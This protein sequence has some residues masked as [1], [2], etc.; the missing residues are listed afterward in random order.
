MNTDKVMCR[1]WYVGQRQ[2]SAITSRARKCHAE[3]M[4]G[5]SVCSGALFFAPPFFSYK[6]L[7]PPCLTSFCVSSPDACTEF[8]VSQS[9][10]AEGVISSWF[11]IRVV[12]TET[13]ASVM[14][15][16]SPDGFGTSLLTTHDDNLTCRNTNTYSDEYLYF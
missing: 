8:V 6:S 4:V 5:R 2:K 15:A 14:G 1:R 12:F 10:L 3:T 13:P 7:F 9:I 11:E 16:L